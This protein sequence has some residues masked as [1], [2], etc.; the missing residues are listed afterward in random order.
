MRMLRTAFMISL[1]VLLAACASPPYSKQGGSLAE[2]SADYQDCYSLGS[3]DHYTPGKNVEV[4]DA[5]D[6]CMQARGYKW[7]MR[8]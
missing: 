3:L 5:T 6:T 8:F 2:A 1:L 7:A 4:K